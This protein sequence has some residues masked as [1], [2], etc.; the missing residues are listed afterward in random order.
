MI[1]H[2]TMSDLIALAA[3]LVA[4]VAIGWTAGYFAGRC[5]RGWTA[6]VVEFRRDR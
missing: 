2:I 6:A 4:G 3:T 1:A 5:A